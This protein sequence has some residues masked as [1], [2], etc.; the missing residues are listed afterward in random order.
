MS[1]KNQLNVRQVEAFKYFMISGSVTGA[2]ELLYIT[3]PAVSRLLSDLEYR[4]GFKLFVRTH[5]KISPTPEAHIFYKEVQRMFVGLDALVKVADSI[6]RNNTGR[7]RIGFMHVVGDFMID[8]VTEF[9][10]A[11][12]N[13]K[14]ELESSG[15]T[16][17]EE[18]IKSSKLDMA[19]ITDAKMNDPAIAVTKMGSHEAKVAIH[20]DNPLAK[21]EF[22]SAEEL[23][24]ERFMVLAYG[25]PFRAKVEAAFDKAQIKRNI[26]L[27]AR[28]QRNLYNLVKNG[29]GTAVLDDFLR[30]DDQLVVMIPFRPKIEWEYSI[31]TLKSNK[32]HLLVK[33]FSDVVLNG[34]KDLKG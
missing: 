22:L 1:S 30:I 20:V 4:V 26:I 21:N 15:R 3:Q 6:T 8:M 13:V 16:L 18:M 34:F 9:L 14:I 23:G 31:I 5:N 27:E 10:A 7:L 12:P 33:A 11:H 19:I 29:V 32:E 24:N 25:S 2:A 17:L 28:T